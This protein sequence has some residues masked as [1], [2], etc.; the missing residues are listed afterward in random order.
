MR[1]ATPDDYKWLY[2]NTDYMHDGLKCARP[3]MV[4][5]VER[6][7]AMFI[8]Y[9]SGRGHLVEWI[10]RHTNGK[11]IEYDPVKHVSCNSS[12]NYITCCDVLE[13]IALGDLSGVLHDIIK[14]A[15]N[16]C[17]F[18]I[19]NMSDIHMVNGEQVQLHLIR[20]DCHWW[21][22]ELMVAVKQ[23]GKEAHLVCQRINSQQFSIIM[24][25]QP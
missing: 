6:C 19:A 10:N 3:I 25:F 14:K 2:A 8:D 24:E 21:E 4:D 17:L 7:P 22:R 13:H 20:Q 11:A 12:A 15:T 1:D 9:G 18:T 5:I 23:C 16:G